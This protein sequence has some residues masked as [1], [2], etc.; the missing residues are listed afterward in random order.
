MASIGDKIKFLR[1]LISQE[2]AMIGPYFVNVNLTTRCN[3]NCVGCRFHSIDQTKKNKIYANKDK[4][5]MPIELFEKI[6]KELKE[7]G[8]KEIILLG[9]GE[10]MLHPEIFDIISMA[11]KYGF[12]LTIITNGTL[13]NE[14][15][16]KKL[17]ENP[18][19]IMK[20]SFW[21]STLEDFKENYPGSDPE[22]INI[23]TNGL[24]LLSKLKKAQAQNLPKVYLHQPINHYNYKNI[25]LLAE[26]VKNVGADF[27]STSLLRPLHDKLE[28]AS[29]SPVEVSELTE[30]LRKIKINIDALGIKHNINETI[31]RYEFGESVWETLPC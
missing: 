21:A 28:E 12:F 6:C 19:D 10:P 1:G 30:N 16:C 5:D 7:I 17:V 23:V 11:K 25:N 20:V 14:T 3:L 4:Y 13:L 9:E 27:M 24:K 29:L 22:N 2:K 15:A 26:T 8:T 18:P 31:M